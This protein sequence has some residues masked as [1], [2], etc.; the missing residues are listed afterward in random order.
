MTDSTIPHPP[1]DHSAPSPRER[2]EGRGEGPPLLDV[3]HLRI[4]F[5]TRRGVLTAVDDVS[6]ALAQGE[7]L[8]VVGESGAGKSLTGAAVIGLLEPPGRI[9]AGEI[10]LE[11]T[12]IDR[13]S[14]DEMRRIRGRRIG[15]IF[16]DPLASLDPLYSIGSQLVETIRTHLPLG[17]AAARARAVELLQE[18]G[19]PAAARRIDHYPH[20][21]SGGMRQ[22]VVIALA[23]AANPKLIIADEPTTALDVSI[24][25]QI[26]TLLRRLCRDHGTAVMLITHDMGVIAETADRVAVMYAGR[27][28]EIGPVADVIRA[29]KHPYT[30][31]LMGSIPSLA[32]DRDRLVQIDGSMPRLTAIPSG[33]PFHP[34]CSR[35]FD[36]CTRERPDLL[37]AGTSRAA[38]WLH[39][40]A[41]A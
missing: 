34:R 31:G 4:E 17:E 20:Q 38:C 35:V 39:V 40:Q 29:P 37:D 18:V 14:H 10:L 27:I 36:R 25:A 16:Q 13:L 24:Q 7:V 5:P 8:G 15:A 21:F 12:R 19:I 6:F 23:L 3:R 32:A 28:V 22:R 30:I 9:S 26:I 41:P 11:G 2:G 33:C 1:R